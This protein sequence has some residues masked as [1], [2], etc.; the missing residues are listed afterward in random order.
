MGREIEGE[1][2]I[3]FRKIAS[4]FRYKACHFG[5]PFLVN[6]PGVR[7]R[8][9]TCLL[10]YKC[11]LHSSAR[12]G[13]LHYI[14]FKVRPTEGI[15]ECASD[16]FQLNRATPSSGHLRAFPT[17]PPMSEPFSEH[18]PPSDYSLRQRCCA[19]QSS[20][21]RSWSGCGVPR[22]HVRSAGS[23][24]SLEEGGRDASKACAEIHGPIRSK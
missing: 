4:R 19:Q 10:P 15:G 12:L 13:S 7:N 6:G 3:L 21:I 16:L 20:N 11:I 23:F 5:R 14:S 22:L 8:G 2:R 17:F 18:S 1:K 24:L 9:Q